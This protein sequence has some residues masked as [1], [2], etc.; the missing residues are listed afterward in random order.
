MHF[1]KLKLYTVETRDASQTL[2][3][4]LTGQAIFPE[5]TANPRLDHK[6]QMTRDM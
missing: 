1:L 5:L 6:N 4:A 2:E 3:L